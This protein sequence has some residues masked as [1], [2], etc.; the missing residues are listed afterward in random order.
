MENICR[1][2]LK[3]DNIDFPAH[4]CKPSDHMK[5]YHA[6]DD[7]QEREHVHFIEKI[8]E[9]AGEFIIIP[10]VFLEERSDYNQIEGDGDTSNRY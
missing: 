8:N 7:P 6:P 3:E 4:P 2:L 1:S 10:P 9:P 5:A